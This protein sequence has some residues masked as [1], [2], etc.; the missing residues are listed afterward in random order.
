MYA[1]TPR[2]QLTEEL[3]QARKD[4]DTFR[5]E[6]DGLAGQL[7]DMTAEIVSP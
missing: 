3:A 1:T 5:L 7:V 6:M 4:L 2:E